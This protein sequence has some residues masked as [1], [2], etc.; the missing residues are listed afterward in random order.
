[1]PT[2]QGHQ[3]LAHFLPHGGAQFET[4][5]TNYNPESWKCKCGDSFFNP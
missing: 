3:S 1:M 4:Q 2:P 5:Q